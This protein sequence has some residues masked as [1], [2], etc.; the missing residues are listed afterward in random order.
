MVVEMMRDDGQDGNFL[1]W[2]KINRIQ[3]TYYLLSI[4]MI[5]PSICIEVTT[6][7]LAIL[8]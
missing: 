2:M 5:D 4:K 1:K 3:V 8:K 6:A 7:N